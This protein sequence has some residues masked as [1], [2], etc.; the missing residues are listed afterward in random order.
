MCEYVCALSSVIAALRGA[1]GGKEEAAVSFCCA[2]LEA[3]LTDLIRSSWAFC[4][5]L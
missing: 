2:Q 4:H 1:A 5:L 3:A